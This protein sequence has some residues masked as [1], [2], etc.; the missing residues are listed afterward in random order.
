M[1]N[2]LHAF[3]KRENA[4]CNSWEKCKKFPLSLQ[5][6]NF[7]PESGSG[8]HFQSSRTRAIDSAHRISSNRIIFRKKFFG[9]KF[10]K[11]MIKCNFFASPCIYRVAKK[12]YFCE[13]SSNFLR[14]N[15]LTK[16]ARNSQ[17]YDFLATLYIDNYYVIY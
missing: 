3:S 9:S 16:I 4:C 14:K 17:K 8:K 12:P 5:E 7:F 15:F 13:F 11:K 6:L 10:M 2:R 1:G